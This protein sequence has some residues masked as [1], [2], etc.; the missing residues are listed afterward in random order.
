AF[1]GVGPGGDVVIEGAVADGQ[2]V[3]VEDAA[4][5]AVGGQVSAEHAV[6]DGQPSVVE[7]ATAVGGQAVGHGQARDVDRRPAGPGED[8]VGAAGGPAHGQEVGP[9]S[10][11]VEVAVQ[12]RQGTGQ[13]DGAADLYGDGVVAGGGVGVEDRL[14]QRAGAAVGQRR[15]GEDGGHR[16][17]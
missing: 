16:P 1:A 2:G 8:A 15:H 7:D 3:G 13:G 4:A 14:P 5:L 11:E 12:V 10:L 9:R 17:V 6:L